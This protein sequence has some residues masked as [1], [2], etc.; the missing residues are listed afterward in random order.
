[1]RQSEDPSPRDLMGKG[2][3]TVS[4]IATQPETKTALDST[5]SRVHEFGLFSS[6]TITLQ[7]T[8]VVDEA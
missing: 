3:V 1:L 7:E 6:L 2:D 4:A 8:D 5:F